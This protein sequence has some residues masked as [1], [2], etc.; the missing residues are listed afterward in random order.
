MNIWLAALILSSFLALA[1]LAAL[2]ALWLRKVR[3]A[4]ALSF[5]ETAGS[6]FRTIQRL[7]ATIDQLLHRQEL[8]E[9]RLLTLTEANIKMRQDLNLLAERLASAENEQRPAP[10]PRLL[11]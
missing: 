1:G 3:E 7:T 11:H 6:Q 9:K 10:A 2:A 5:S 8:Y 4:L